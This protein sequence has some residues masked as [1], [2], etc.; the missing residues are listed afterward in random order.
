[1][2]RHK[3]PNPSADLI[4]VNT[5]LRRMIDE[6]EQRN[7]D[8]ENRVARL[9]RG[10]EH[11]ADKVSACITA[12]ANPDIAPM[13]VPASLGEP[14]PAPAKKAGKHLEKNGKPYTDDEV[15]LAVL[16]NEQGATH[17]QVAAV[18][19]R[20]PHAVQTLLSRHRR[21]EIGGSK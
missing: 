18:L 11:L 21:G 10:T 8:L 5:V 12:V 14:T 9:E 19:H 16:M 15:A 17:A 13:P 6:L 20:T 2:R 4:E 3:R 1:M 7:K